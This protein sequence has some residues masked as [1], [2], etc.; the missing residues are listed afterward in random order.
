MGSLQ[1]FP[2]PSCL[3]W[4][5]TAKARETEIGPKPAFLRKNCHYAAWYFFMKYRLFMLYFLDTE[6]CFTTYHSKATKHN[7]FRLWSKKHES[8]ENLKKKFAGWEECIIDWWTSNWPL[9]EGARMRVLKWEKK[10]P[11]APHHSTHTNSFVKVSPHTS[12]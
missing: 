6:S 5:Q 7:S 9:K 8:I 3:V 12:V 4:Q 10:I 2:N 11:P 1:L